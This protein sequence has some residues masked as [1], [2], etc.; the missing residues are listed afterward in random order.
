MLGPGAH[1]QILPRLGDRRQDLI[2]LPVPQ[3]EQES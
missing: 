3:T 1:P 2:L